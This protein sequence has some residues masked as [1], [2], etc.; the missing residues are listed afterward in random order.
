MNTNY[1]A[2]IAA[3]LSGLVTYGALSYLITMLF[4]N[5]D[6]TLFAQVFAAMTFMVLVCTAGLFRKFYAI[7]GNPEARE[8]LLILWIG[9][10]VF[11]VV[12]L[13][14]FINAHFFD[15]WLAVFNSPFV[16][17]QSKID[18]LILQSNICLIG[19]SCIALIAAC[20]EARLAIVKLMRKGFGVTA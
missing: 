3:S 16:G 20:V 7:P 5:P 4:S 19:L 8:E 6:L 17:D 11:G 12:E 13:G 9:T 1:K 15:W 2:D 14:S 10:A 18:S